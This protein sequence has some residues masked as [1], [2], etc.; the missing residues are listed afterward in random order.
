[1]VALCTYT[2]SYCRRSI[3]T[4][5]VTLGERHYHAIENEF[6]ERAERSCYELSEYGTKTL[7]GNFPPASAVQIGESI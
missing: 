2:C 1:M 5:F 7:S 4:S 6:G 3:E